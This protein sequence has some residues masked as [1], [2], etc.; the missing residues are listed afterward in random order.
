MLSEEC[1][2][3]KFVLA[4]LENLASELSYNLGLILLLA[5]LQNMLYNVVTILILDQADCTLE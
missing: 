2:P 4:E 5:M 1:A 3:S